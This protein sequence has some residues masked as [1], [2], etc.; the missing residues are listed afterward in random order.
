M[1]NA[2]KSVVITGASSGIGRTCV[3]QMSKAGWQIFA[4]V[5][6]AEDRNKLLDANIPNVSPVM[7]DIEDV[8]RSLPLLKK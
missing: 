6:K 4:T 1:S 8:L 5:R 2:R 7:M 3:L